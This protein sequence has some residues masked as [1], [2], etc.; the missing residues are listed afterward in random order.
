MKINIQEIKSINEAEEYIRD[1][2]INQRKISDEEKIKEAIQSLQNRIQEKK[3]HVLI[4][5]ESDNIIGHISG[6]DAG[7]VYEVNSF[8]IKDEHCKNDIGYELIKAMTSK[9]FELGFEHYRHGNSLPFNKES[10]FEENLK[11]DGYLL[12]TRYEMVKELTSEDDFSYVMPEGYSFEPFSLEKVDEIMQV[13]VDANP[14]GHTD[15]HIYPEMRDVEATKKVFGSF[16]DNFKAFDPAINPQIVINGKIIGMSC[17]FV[18]V[19]NYAFVAEVSIVPEH[20][21]KGLGKAL[22]NEIMQACFDKG[23]NKLGL[24]V[25]KDNTGAYKLYQKLGYTEVKE[26]LVVIKHK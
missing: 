5:K 8:F 7:K 12:F 10:T 23:Y 26:Y 19:E 25:T 2:L 1:F 9:A 4:A 17:I 20:Q 24:A 11:K 13:M 16:S 3:S 15:N 18:P 22:M 14:E 6:R 21:R